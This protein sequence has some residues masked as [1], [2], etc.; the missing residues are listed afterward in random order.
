MDPRRLAGLGCLLPVCPGLPR[1]GR[2]AVLTLDGLFGLV[3]RDSVKNNLPFT[4]DGQI[5]K[6]FFKFL[7]FFIHVTPP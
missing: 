3:N 1:G 6:D 4:F 2:D 7:F 5:L